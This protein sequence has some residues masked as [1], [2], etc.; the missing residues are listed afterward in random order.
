[1]RK[2]QKQIE[3]CLIREFLTNALDLTVCRLWGRCPPR[4]DSYAVIERDG[5]SVTV[6][7][8]STEYQ[9]DTASGKKGGSPGVRLHSFWRKVQESLCRRLTRKPIEVDV[10]VTLK[11][12]SKVN[13]DDSHDFAEELVQLA[14]GFKFP[15]AGVAKLEVFLPEYPLLAKYVKQARLKKVGF[16]SIFW[17]CTNTLAANVGLIPDLVADHIRTKSNK[18]Y[19]WAKNSEKW[20]LVCA[21]GGSIV[22]TAGPPPASV[23]WQDQGLQD[24]CRASPFDRVYFWD[25]PHS[26]SERLK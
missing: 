20:L 18:K 22:G 7:I 25:R 16:Y 21:S 19:K 4:P 6:E 11:D 12:P 15:P 23:R 13:P 5:A 2:R 26:W 14:R 24:A 3:K 9:V 17:T 8:E 1:M 10:C